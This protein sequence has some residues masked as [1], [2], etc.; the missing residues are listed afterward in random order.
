LSYTKTL[1]L[2]KAYPDLKGI[3]AFGSLGPIGAAQALK[4][5]RLC[6]KVK[7]VGTVLPSHGARYLRNNCMQYGYLWDP[8]DA[9]YA[10]V[11]LAHMILE[12]H[13]IRDGMEIPGL[14]GNVGVDTEKRVI[15]FDAVIDINSENA[16]DL[17][18]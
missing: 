18:F 15:K 6:G 12:G 14:T 9:G 2:L 3:V 10:M 11:T 17:G 1:E 4:E 16:S 13:E 5:K 8:K 7:V